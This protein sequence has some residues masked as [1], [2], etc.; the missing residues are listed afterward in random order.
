MN[1][2]VD[3]LLTNYEIKGKGPGILLLH[4]WGDTLQTFSDLS[5]K[6]SNQYTVIALDLPGFGATQAPQV[7]YDLEKYAR[8]VAAFLEKIDKKASAVVGHSNGGAIAIK[9]ASLKVLEADKL[10]LI[11]SSGVRSTYRSRKKALRLAAKAAKVSIK[12]LP[13]PT[14][15]KIK[16]KAYSSIGSDLLVSEHMQETFKNIVEEDLV[17]LSSLVKQ[18]TLL[19]YGSNDLA[20]P[21]SY[22]RKFAAKLPNSQLRIIDGAGHFLHH[23]HGSQVEQLIIDFLEQRT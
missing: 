19:I 1:V 5:S 16:K 22:G 4:G 11:A 15:K 6:L 13:K 10:I 14:Q 21:A 12:V 7:A 18:K 17:D 3:G 9:A 20:T 8:F 2:V 23:T